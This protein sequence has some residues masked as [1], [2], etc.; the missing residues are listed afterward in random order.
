MDKKRTGGPKGSGLTPAIIEYEKIVH[1]LNQAQIAKKYG[2]TR[3]NVS[4]IKRLRGGYS[5]TP[6]ER[7]MQ[8]WPWKVPTCHQRC[9][10]HHRMRDHAELVATGGKGMSRDKLRRLLSFYTR[11]ES[12]NLVVEYHP[13]IPPNPDAACGGWRYV[14]REDADGDLMI[15]VN[16]HT[17]VT[18]EGKMLWRIPRKEIWPRV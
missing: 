5:M 8:Q 4:Q 11:L 9:N 15:R 18:E 1:G 10:I 17:N 12:E 16:E 2:T 13:D 6:R 7:V 3:Q 14:P